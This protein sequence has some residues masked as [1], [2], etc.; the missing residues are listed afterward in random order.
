[1]LPLGSIY[2]DH[3]PFKFMHK[4][5]YDSFYVIYIFVSIHITLCYALEITEEDEDT[6]RGKDNKEDKEEGHR[7]DAKEVE[8][9][10][11]ISSDV[12]GGDDKQSDSHN[13]TDTE[14]SKW[15]LLSHESSIIMLLHTDNTGLNCCYKS[16]AKHYNRYC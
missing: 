9:Q 12:N 6:C 11:V 1:M 8:G 16:S 4:L 13:A 15:I 14:Y 3:V 7:E 2:L 5:F 10:R